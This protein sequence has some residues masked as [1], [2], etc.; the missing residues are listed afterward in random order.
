MLHHSST[1]GYWIIRKVNVIFSLSNRKFPHNRTY[2]IT[3]QFHIST[4]QIQKNPARLEQGLC[5]YNH[6][7]KCISK[8]WNYKDLAHKHIVHFHIMLKKFMYSYI[9]SFNTYNT[10]YTPLFLFFAFEASLLFHL[11]C[12][13]KQTKGH[14]D[15]NSF[16][17]FVAIE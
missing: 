14:R 4:P 6:M 9:A 13:Y 5:T 3:P 1:Y 11:L 15:E 17:S 8:S 16:T 7:E 12:F 10:H 2:R